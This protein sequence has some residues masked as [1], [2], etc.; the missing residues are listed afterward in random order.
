MKFIDMTCVECGATHRFRGRNAKEVIAGI[1]RLRWH[2]SA[3]GTEDRCPK[4]WT[5]EVDRL[6]EED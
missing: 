2:D 4:C 3:D 6:E 5:K 1:D